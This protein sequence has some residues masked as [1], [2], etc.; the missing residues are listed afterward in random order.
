V[1]TH[2]FIASRRT[3]GPL[4][5]APDAEPA[6]GAC[7]DGDITAE[8]FEALLEMDHEPLRIPMIDL[9]RLS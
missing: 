4:D 6:S 3:R 1:K 9:L 8:D 2:R 5:H 7:D